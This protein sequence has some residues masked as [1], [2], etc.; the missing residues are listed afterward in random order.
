MGGAVL[1][2]RSVPG[3]DRRPC[4]RDADGLEDVLRLGPAGLDDAPRSLWARLF[5]DALFV[6]HSAGYRALT[7]VI[8]GN[9]RRWESFDKTARIPAHSAEGVIE[10]MP[11]TDGDVYGFKYVNGHPRNTARG[12]PT[13]MA[14]GVLAEVDTGY[15]LLLSELTLTTALRTAATSAMAAQLLAPR[16][17]RRVELLVGECLDAGIERDERAGPGPGRI[18]DG[19]G[20]PGPLP[21]ADLQQPIGCPVETAY[22]VHPDRSSHRQLLVLLVVGEPAR[23]GEVRP[24]TTAPR[25]GTIGQVGDAVDVVHGERVPAVLPGSP[26]LLAR[27]QDHVINTEAHQVEG[28]GQARLSGSDPHRGVHV[29]VG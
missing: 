17:A 23:D 8:E 1:L 22:G 11:T 27:V 16:I 25:R 21:R 3:R 6:P 12:L 13:V 19:A 29:H 26:G 10:L 7:E 4:E 5:R 2:A 9:F 18:H 24:V 20:Q 15:P 28:R 14:F